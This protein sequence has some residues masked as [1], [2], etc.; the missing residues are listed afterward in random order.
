MADKLGIYNGA[1]R[2]LG[3]RKLASLTED[4]PARYYLD[5]AWDDGLIQ[6]CLE[7]GYWNFATRTIL[8]TPET[9]I[10][11]EFGYRKAYQ[12]PTDYVK[13][14]A[15]STDEYFRTTLHQYSDE[16]EYWFC[17]YDPLYIQYISNDVDYGFNPGKWTQSF[18]DFVKPVLADEVKELITGSDGKYDRIKKAL[19]DAKTSARS[20]DA[21]NRPPKFGQTGSWVSARMSGVV[22]TDRYFNGG[23]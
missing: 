22:N 7:E 12:K 9:G 20:K 6:R 3:E 1:L 14:K 10:E 21:M 5:D 16:S 19:K 8:A 23:G 17:D 13:L 11:P 4:R 2:L 15:I 18:E